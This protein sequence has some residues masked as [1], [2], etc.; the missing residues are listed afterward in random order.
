MLKALVPI[1]GSQ[2]ALGAIRHVIRLVQGREPLDIHLLNVQAPF[3]GDVTAFVPKGSVHDFHREQGH[4]A[5]AAA[6]AL[7]SESGIPY[8]KHIFVGHPAQVI[9]D[10]AKQLGC[11]KVIMGTRGCGTI[12][13]LLLGSIS[14]DAIHRMDCRIPVTL[15]KAGYGETDPPERS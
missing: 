12:T 8:T 5:M 2:N 10:V 3:H 4:K 7:L 6:C 14:H 13:Q 9:A 1:D 11:D 15:V